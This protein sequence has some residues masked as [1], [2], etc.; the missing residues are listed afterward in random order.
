MIKKLFLLFL[1]FTF[2]IIQAQKR[3]IKLNQKAISKADN[4]DFVKAIK[5]YTKALSINPEFTDA[6]NNRALSY[7]QLEEIDKAM[8]DFSTIL[9]IDPNL[10]EAYFNR[11]YCMKRRVIWKKQ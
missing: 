6:L 2:T 8:K 11:G 4:G 3:E 10:A 5:L 1:L 9:E 7:I